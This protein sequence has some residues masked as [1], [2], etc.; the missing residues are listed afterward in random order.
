MPW[1]LAGDSEVKPRDGT[2][3]CVVSARGVTL[4]I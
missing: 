4:N 1:K 2:V 3:F